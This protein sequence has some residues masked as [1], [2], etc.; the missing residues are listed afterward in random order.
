MF[1]NIIKNA[2]INGTPENVKFTKIL[3]GIGLGASLISGIITVIQVCIE[4]NTF[5]HKNKK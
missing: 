4:I 5:Y 2:F 3:S 1:S